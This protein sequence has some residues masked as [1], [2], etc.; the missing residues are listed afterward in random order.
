LPF[1]RNLQRYNTG[2]NGL[3]NMGYEMTDPQRWEEMLFCIA[4][5]LMQIVL[6][7]FIL[8]T[9]FHYIVKKDQAVENFRKRLVMLEEY[10]YTRQLPSELRGR[11]RKHFEFQYQKTQEVDTG[12]LGL[13]P[14]SLKMKVAFFQYE[15]VMERNMGLFRGCNAQFLNMLVVALRECY[16][17]PGEAVIQQRDMSRALIFV[18]T[19]ALELLKNSQLIGTVRADSDLPSVVGQVPFFMSIGQ[20]YT[21]GL[22]RLNQVDP[23]PITYNLSNP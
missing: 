13:M 6:E 8:G 10:G 15:D 5:V 21:V 20:P 1:K 14:S 4:V 22:C 9:L 18:R 2:F 19:G 3:T 17:M 12:V 11:L 23:Y 7:A 16:L